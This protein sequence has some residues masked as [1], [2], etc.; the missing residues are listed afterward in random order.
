[1]S[2]VT[3]IKI[4]ILGDGT[5][6]KSSLA[7]RFAKGT[8]SDEYKKTLGVDFLMKR[9]EVDNSLIEFLIWDTAGQ[10]Y[11]DSITKR[12]YKGANAAIVVF[13]VDNKESFE[14]VNKWRDKIISECGRIPIVLVRNK[15]DIDINKQIIS[16][17]EARFLADKYRLEMFNV[18][19]KENIEVSNIFDSIARRII[20]FNEEE[21][22]KDKP[23]EEI[24]QS[25][26]LKIINKG[27]DPEEG[28][29]KKWK[30]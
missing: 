3:S 26:G 5:V 18:S 10:E 1:M 19:V 23:Q 13:S 14:S 11:Y 21:E 6:G 28:K 30:C 12:Y 25:F 16:I 22:K 8:F 29:K 20:L 2:E 15:I 7:Q 27:K 17:E 9:K 24:K 4:I